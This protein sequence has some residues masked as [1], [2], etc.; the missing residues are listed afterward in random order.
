MD[1]RSWSVLVVTACLAISISNV[2]RGQGEASRYILLRSGG[3]TINPKTDYFTISLAQGWLSK[4]SRFLESLFSSDAKSDI[5]L[6]S[7]TTFFD[8]QKVETALTFSNQDIKKNVS[9][10]WGFNPQLYDKLP[11]DAAPDIS[12]QVAIST[13]DNVAKILAAVDASK[14]S[15]PADVIASPVLG[16]ARVVSGVF[17]AL[18]GTDATKYPFIWQGSV[19]AASPAI[20]AAGMKEH[21]I[22][23]IAPRDAGD[24]T[25]KNLTVA[26]L[27]FDEA[28]QRLTYNNVPVVDWSFAV[29]AVQKTTP[30]DIDLLMNGQSN[31]PWAVL[32]VNVFRVIPTADAA[33]VEQLQTLAKS[34]VAQ[35]NNMTDLLKRELRFSAYSRAVT[36]ASL[37]TRARDQIKI[38]CTALAI[39]DAQCP[40]SELDQ[41]ANSAGRLF[42][43]SAAQGRFV[44]RDAQRTKAQ[45]FRSRGR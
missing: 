34:L 22:V 10:S 43:L 17:R 20:T 4:N 3:A 9:K 23:L 31:A 7:G 8:G 29:F 11:G 5:L 28:N 39:P 2:A 33:K 25:Y 26:N 36:V 12:V 27:A 30:Y 1:R 24:Q 45:L 38:R 6:Q 15:V 32:G 37:A 41:V 14:A 13:A 35:L 44:I 42:G 40:V 16:Y 18:F 21:Y 19:K